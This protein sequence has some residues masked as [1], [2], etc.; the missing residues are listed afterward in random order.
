MKLR[1]YQVNAIL[2]WF[3]FYKDG[4]VGNPLIGMPTGTGKS[5]VIACL[6]CEIIR[7]HPGQRILKLTHVKE[8]IGQNYKALLSVWPN[9]PAGIYSA[10]L[11]RKDA[12]YP[13]TYA[14][15]GSIHKKAH[16]FQ[17]TDVIII[18]EAHLLGPKESAMYQRFIAD[19][20]RYNPYVIVTGLSATLFR[21]GQGMLTNDGLFTHICYDLTGI[22][23]FNKLIREGFLA[24]LV[25]LRTKNELDIEGLG[26]VK[27]EFKTAEMEDRYKVDKVIIAALEEAIVQ[28]YHRKHWLIFTTGVESCEKVTRLLNE[29]YGI[30]ACA[31]HSGNDVFPMSSKERDENIAAFKRGD[32]R[33]A[34]NN[35]VLTT[36]FDYPLIDLIIVLRPTNSPGLWVQM[37]GRGTRPVWP[38]VYKMPDSAGNMNNYHLWP[39][40]YVESGRYYLETDEGRNLCIKEGPK[41]NCLV[42]DFA[43]NT[44]RLGPINDPVIPYAKKKGGVKREA[45]VKIC[46]NCGMYCHCSI[47]LCPNCGYEFPRH[48]KLTNEASDKELIAVEVPI[49]IEVLAVRHTVYDLHSKRDKPDSLRVTYECGMRHFPAFKCFEHPEPSG[50][51]A[52]AWWRKASHAGGEAPQTTVE[53]LSR[54]MEL[55]DATHIRVRLDTKFPEVKDVDYSGTAFGSIQ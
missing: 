47:R 28:G 10:G 12:G 7:R 8:L 1:Y 24:N 15:I 36:G 41:Q 18:D 30:S 50:H 11:D 16:I 4:N 17:K 46:D 14:G 2:A 48:V 23:P 9:A 21:L 26:I 27:G 20:K 39:Q 34:V 19:L 43:A 45:P 51:N 32:F 55:R 22:E 52:R 40:H 29:K 13:I 6:I 35:N 25:P 3:K 42:L 31:V 54:T 44:K 37:L 33:A 38:E 49:R 53:A 5:L